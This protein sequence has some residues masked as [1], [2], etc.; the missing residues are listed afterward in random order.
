MQTLHHAYTQ[1]ARDGC[2]GRIGEKISDMEVFLCCALLCVCCSW[3]WRMPTSLIASW[4]RSVAAAEAA[5]A[6]AGVEAAEEQQQPCKSQ[7]QQQQQ[8]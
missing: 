6:A 3:V 5:A 1:Q 2:D 4:S 7:Q 8:L